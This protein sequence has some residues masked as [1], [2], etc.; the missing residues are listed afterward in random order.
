MDYK[1][2][3]LSAIK[4]YVERQI[5]PFAKFPFSDEY[6]KILLMNGVKNQTIIIPVGIMTEEYAKFYRNSLT[7]IDT[8]LK[9]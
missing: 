2:Y 4:K 8:N 7:A 1:D 5:F 3:L 9:F 6:S